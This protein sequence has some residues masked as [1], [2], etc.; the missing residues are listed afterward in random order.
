MLPIA[1]LRSLR[2]TT[3]LADTSDLPE[4]VLIFVCMK[5]I[6]IL[7]IGLLISSSMSAQSAKGKR[8]SA[9][10][11][12]IAALQD[13]LPI[14]YQRLALTQVRKDLETI[15]KRNKGKLPE[16]LSSYAA[17]LP[18]AERMLSRVE[19]VK[20]LARHQL[21][22]AEVQSKLLELS[23]ALG[24]QISIEHDSIQGPYGGFS[25]PG[26]RGYRFRIVADDSK[27]DLIIIEYPSASASHTEPLSEVINH[28]NTPERFPFVLSDGVRLLFARRSTEGIGGYDLYLSRYSWERKAFLEP[29]L[30]GMPF[31]SPANDYLLAYDEEQHRSYLL[32]DRGLLGSGEVTLYVLE[33]LPKALSN[34]PANDSDTALSSEEQLRYAQLDASLISIPQAQN[35]E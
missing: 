6:A 8:A 7:G 24:R 14:H 22:W 11:P 21:K 19:P 3:P 2:A 33:G 27:N 30:L 20:L 10:S 34:T 25:S 4:F 5:K 17:F 26:N 15:S 31:N 18:R 13:S 1:L 32:S 9:S 29:S 16:G 23:P 28:P 35:H 12:S